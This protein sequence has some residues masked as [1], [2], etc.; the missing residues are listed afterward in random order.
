MQNF[1]LKLTIEVDQVGNGLSI[2][3]PVPLDVIYERGRW[4]A[5]CELPP[6]FSPQMETLEAA[7]AAGAKQVAIELQAA[8]EDRP[9]IVG[10][11]TPADVPEIF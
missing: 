11:I 10:R 1:R 2:Q 5:Q 3:T 6:V 7:I 4:H 8:V 9:L